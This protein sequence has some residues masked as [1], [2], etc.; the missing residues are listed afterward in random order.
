MRLHAYV[1]GSRVEKIESISESQWIQDISNYEA[2]IDIEDMGVR[3]LVGWVADSALNFEPAEPLSNEQ[4][5]SLQQAAQRIYGYKLVESLTDKVGSRNLLLSSQ[6]ESVNVSS[7]LQTLGGI[8]GLMETGSLKTARGAIPSVKPML[9][10]YE[11]ILDAAIAS[12]T[13]FLVENDYE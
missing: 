7:L 8:K 10:L 6:G 3:P 12:I 4:A 9:P 11:D 1:K 2:I 13:A 5:L